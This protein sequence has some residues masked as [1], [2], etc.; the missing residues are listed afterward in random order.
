MNSRSIVALFAGLCLAV[1][2]A[3]GAAVAGSWAMING[4]AAVKSGMTGTVVCLDKAGNNLLDGATPKTHI[5][6]TGY[7][8]H[9]TNAIVVTCP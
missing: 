2:I 3:T 4:T 8:G 5:Q 7:Q 1:S 6:P 9:T